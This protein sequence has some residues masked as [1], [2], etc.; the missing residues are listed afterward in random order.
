MRAAE[1]TRWIVAVAAVDS[2]VAGAR[3]AWNEASRLPSPNTF[4][5]TLTA[6]HNLSPTIS[7][8]LVLIDDL[9]TM[10]C[11]KARYSCDCGSTN[12]AC[13][14]PYISLQKRVSRTARE[15]QLA[16]CFCLQRYLSVGSEDI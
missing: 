16:H 8:A 11:H 12:M 6:F 13:I 5:N 3:G 4:T 9:N 7:P 15:R 1:R 14:P 2:F 10:V